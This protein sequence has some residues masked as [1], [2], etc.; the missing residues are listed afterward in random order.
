MNANGGTFRPVKKTTV[1]ESIIQQVKEMMRRNQY[2]AGSRLPSER[3]LAE[4]LGVSRPSLREALQT[5]ALM[6]VLDTR[7]GSGTQVAQ[8]ASNVL[9]MPLEFLCLLDNP[10]VSDLHETRTLIEVFLAGR[11]AER[12]NEKDLIAMEAAI[13]QMKELV[14]DPVAFTEPDIR[15]H[16][17]LAAAA[18][19]KLLEN[20]MN[21][22][23]ESVRAMVRKAWPGE[24]DMMASV[25]AHRR[26][27]EAIRRKDPA[28]A[29]RAMQKHMTIMTSELKQAKV[30]K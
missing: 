21:T 16:R 17:A 15:F 3:D 26:I 5:L 2:V 8:S 9:K 27:C 6:G 23:Q 28:E 19:N 4:E 24:P 29:R 12:R 20:M 11:A 30:I 7:H 10:S 18:R 13:A 25:R 22:L 14:D 1:V